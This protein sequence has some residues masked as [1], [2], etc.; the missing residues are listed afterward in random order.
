MEDGG[1]VYDLGVIGQKFSSQIQTPDIVNMCAHALHS[2]PVD[3]HNTEQASKVMRS[4]FNTMG[5]DSDCGWAG[6]Y[7]VCVFIMNLIE[8]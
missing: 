2:E 3:V 7:D 5:S 6:A 8:V 4:K 1:G